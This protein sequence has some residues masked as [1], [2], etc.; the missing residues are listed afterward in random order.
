[1]NWK[2]L[3]NCDF[4]MMIQREVNVVTW[5]CLLNETDTGKVTLN[6]N[7]NI[8]NVFVLQ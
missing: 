4:H 1:M 7:K 6:A 2:W 3:K 8:F 5:N